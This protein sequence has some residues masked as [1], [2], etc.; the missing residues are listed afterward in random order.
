TLSNWL[1]PGDYL[2][3]IAKSASEKSLVDVNPTLATAGKKIEWAKAL[4]GHVPSSVVQPFADNAVIAVVL[5]SLLAGLALRKTSR[6]FPKEFAPVENVIEV[7]HRVVEHIITLVVKLV[8]IAVFSVVAK[9]VGEHGLAPLKGLAVYL[10][11]CL[12]GLFLQAALVYQSWIVFVARTGFIRFWTHAREAVTYALGASSSLATLPVTLRGLDQLGVT[13]ESS[14][15]AACVGTNLNNDGILLYEALA[16]LLVAQAYGIELSYLEQIGVAISC[17][18]AGIGIAGVPEAG[19]ISLALVLA[20]AGLP[21]ELLPV[22]LSVDWVL[23]RARAATNV[24]ADFTVALL[25]D[26]WNQKNS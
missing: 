3:D 8:P 6:E 19:L 4:A 1:R 18:I 15:L 24:L 7:L 20:T 5:L 22:L 14:R 2:R 17:V 26:R 25:L 23:S 21:L 9:T 12:L 16:A 11:V 13:R 10:G